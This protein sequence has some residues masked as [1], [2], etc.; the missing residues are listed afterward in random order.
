MSTTPGSSQPAEKNT[1]VAALCDAMN[2]VETGGR[3]SG[4]VEIAI[5]M[6]RQVVSG[7]GRLKRCK[8][9][10][11]PVRAD[12]ENGAAAVA[13]V[14]IPSMVEGDPRGDTHAFHPLLGAAIRRNAMN[15]AVVA[16]GNE[17]ISRAI[18]REPAGIHQRRDEWLHAVIRG[19][20]VERHRNALA[21]W[22]GERDVNVAVAIHRRIRDRMKIVCDLQ[23][24]VHRMWLALQAG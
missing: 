23:P 9:K 18:Q 1:D 15:G 22:P 12:L 8:N 13:D 11:L 21:P 3:R 17:K 20:F 4:D 7:D 24:D 16:A 10:N 6:K 14:K 19:D 2:T 5:R